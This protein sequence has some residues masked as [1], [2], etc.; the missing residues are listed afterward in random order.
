[1]ELGM[2]H[3]VAFQVGDYE[4][5]K[6]FYVDTLGFQILGEYPYPNGTMRLDCRRGDARLELFWN[7]GV[8]AMI[9]QPH[10]GYRHLCFQTNAIHETAAWLRE[11]GIKVEEIRPDPM[12]G[13]LM[14]FFYDPD[15]MQLELH[16]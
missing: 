5:A 4:K 7:A 1:M 16:E 2:V 15:G 9:E 14:T 12:A 8:T 6:A 11:K 10:L 13:G 3:H